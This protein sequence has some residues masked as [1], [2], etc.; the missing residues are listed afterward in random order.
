[1]KIEGKYSS[2]IENTK[3]LF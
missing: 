2:V 3:W 1:M